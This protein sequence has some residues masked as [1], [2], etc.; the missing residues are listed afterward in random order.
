MWNS[1]MKANAIHQSYTSFAL[2]YQAFAA[3][4]L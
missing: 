4:L 2:K 1:S 3:E